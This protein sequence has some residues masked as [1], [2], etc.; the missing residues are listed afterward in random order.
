MVL[1]SSKVNNEYE[2]IW[3]FCYIK[4]LYIRANTIPARFHSLFFR[5]FLLAELPKCESVN[6]FL[7]YLILH[8]Y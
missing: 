4:S 6:D 8:N 3:K 5:L 1:L 7:V 2:T